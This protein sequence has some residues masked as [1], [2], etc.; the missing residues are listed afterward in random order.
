M[1]GERLSKRGPATAGGCSAAGA[2]AG[3]QPLTDAKHEETARAGL[4]ASCVNAKVV[5]SSRGSVFYFCQVSLTDPEFP[6]YPSLPVLCCRGYLA[7]V[8]EGPSV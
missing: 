8:P 3:G 6:R 4:C 7:V 5:T 1:P 2:R